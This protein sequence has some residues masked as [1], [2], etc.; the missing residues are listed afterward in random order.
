MKAAV[1]A[2][3]S[4]LTTV[5]SMVS[6]SDAGSVSGSDT[7]KS[8]ADASVELQASKLEQPSECLMGAASASE[9]ALLSAKGRALSMEQTKAAVSAHA[10][11]LIK[12]ANMVSGSDAES[13]SGS[14]T[15]KSTA[16]ASVEK[17]AS[18]ME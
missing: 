15:V 5:A 8:T 17:Q 9:P 2:H 6:G 11:V 4:V 14:D 18:M 3:A 13:V 1:S 7:V 10:S 16:G 12:V